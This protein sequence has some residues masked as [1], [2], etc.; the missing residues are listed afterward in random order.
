[1]KKNV[2][3]L[4]VA[5]AVAASAQA[6]MYVNH[7]N[8]GE[9]LIYPF[10]SA[11]NGNE[12][13]I[14][15]VNT[16]QYAKAAKVRIHEAE[17]SW[18]VRDF[19]LYLSPYDH[20]AFAISL[21]ESGAGKLDTADTSCT[22][23]AI[24]EGGIEF[25][26]QLF[27][28][29]ENASLER[30]LNGYVEIIEMGQFAMTAPASATTRG[31]P[32]YYWEHVDGVPRDC[33]YV[34]SLWSS[35]GAWYK[36]VFA[37]PSTVVGE[38]GQ[39]ASWTG[40]GL[41]GM[42]IMVNPE[43]GAA[44]G[45]D[46]VAIE[47]FVNSDLSTGTKG[48][49]LHYYPGDVK[50]GLFGRSGV[51]SESAIVA[52]DGQQDTYT[53]IARA[54][55]PSKTLDAVSALMMVDEITNDYVLDEFFSGNTDWIV[56]FPTKRLYVK[57]DGD[58]VLERAVNPFTY[59]W[60]GNKA[61]DPYLITVWDREED[62][63]QQQVD[64]PPFSPYTGTP[65]TVPEICY[66]ANVMTFAKAGTTAESPIL[67]LEP[68]ASGARIQSVVETPYTNGWARM[69]LDWDVIFT[70]VPDAEPKGGKG[71]ILPMS[72][73]GTRGDTLEGLPA[74]GFSVI[75]F[76]NDSI[77]GGSVLANYAAAHEHKHDRSV[78]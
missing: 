62:T 52:V 73:S 74:V 68:S 64:Q 50:P 9:V 41:Y 15:V 43:D 14:H 58:T 47:N 10:Y 20:F 23:P 37:T 19:N 30:T 44:V 56:T 63:P 36:E 55:S 67:G 1:M 13:Y 31:A 21:D 8:T 22:V 32:G 6:Q 5:G 2:L 46:A 54:G 24:P 17:N 25:T 78:S 18:E 16:T 75:A 72:S 39:L 38:T 53:A 57:G 65:G 4:A 27:A 7:D 12:T 40:G 48:A 35:S 29:E 59:E 45:Y 66:E 51:T 34:V 71:H 77:S 70:A 33:P 3:T 26:N 28:K 60:L 11:D 49:A 42:G 76:G 61:C 69:D